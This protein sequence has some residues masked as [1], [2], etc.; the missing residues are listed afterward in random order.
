MPS[1]IIVRHPD[2]SKALQAA[3]GS[4]GATILDLSNRSGANVNFV[5]TDDT[6]VCAFNKRY[7]KKK[8]EYQ[9]PEF[10]LFTR[11]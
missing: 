11:R 4:V 3:L 9:C 2:I 1:K 5:F 8:R 10:S 6:E 7:R